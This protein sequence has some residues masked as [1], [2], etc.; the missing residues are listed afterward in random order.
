MEGHLQSESK[1]QV[2]LLRT[3]QSTKRTRSLSRNESK[4]VG[5]KGLEK[6]SR[7]IKNKKKAR[8][9]RTRVIVKAKGNHKGQ[10]KG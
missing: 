6:R 8:N 10:N 1:M 5:R 3:N 7:V 2:H 9:N 4:E